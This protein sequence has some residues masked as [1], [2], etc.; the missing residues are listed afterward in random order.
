MNAVSFILRPGEPRRFLLAGAVNTVATYLLYRG[1]L[2]FLSYPLA[3]TISY[4]AGIL[5]SFVLNSRYVFRQPLTWDG[6]LR[7]PIVYAAQYLIGLAVLS[8][9]LTVG[10]A[11]QWLAFGL[12]T[13]A[14]VPVTFILAR[15]AV[16][17]RSSRPP[18]TGYNSE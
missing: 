2:A 3:Y 6:F 11:P 18:H 7:F 12:S 5:L 1:L 17:G 13:A 8:V 15:W 4:G 16:A 10:R 14:A 9:A